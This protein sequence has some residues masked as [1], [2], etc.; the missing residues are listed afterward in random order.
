MVVAQPVVHRPEADAYIRTPRQ[1]HGVA[2]MLIVEP[3]N[4]RHRTIRLEVTPTG[5]RGVVLPI[6]VEGTELMWPQGRAKLAGPLARLG[7]AAG[8]DIGAPV[9][10]Y[11]SSASLSADAV[12]DLDAETAARAHDSLHIGAHALR[13]FTADQQPVLWPEHFD[14]GLSRRRRNYGVSTRGCVPRAAICL[15]RTA[16]HANRSVLERTFQSG[17]ITRP[18]DDVDEIVDFFT[19]GK[20]HL[21]MTVQPLDFT[22]LRAL[23]INCT[24]KRSPEPSHTQGLID[25]STRIMQPMA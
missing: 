13:A 6:A 19:R 8:V 14:V 1:L 10:V 2:E 20:E 9:G 23:F 4:R 3:Q 12:L 7:A 24:L 22:G 16:D 17:A 15:R 25:I 21:H 18:G 5:F 11:H